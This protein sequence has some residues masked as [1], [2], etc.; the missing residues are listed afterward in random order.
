[1]TVF[2]GLKPK[3]GESKVM[4]PSSLKISICIWTLT[5]AFACAAMLF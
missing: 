4:E 2:A 3:Q 1:M 5:L